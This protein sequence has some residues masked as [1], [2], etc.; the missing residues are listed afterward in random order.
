MLFFFCRV[1][2]TLSTV[3]NFYVTNLFVR[4]YKA[5]HIV[6]KNVF[7]CAPEMTLDIPPLVELPS[8]PQVLLVLTRIVCPTKNTFYGNGTSL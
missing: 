1:S 8:R 5:A 4:V 7:V 3:H 2:Y 6:A